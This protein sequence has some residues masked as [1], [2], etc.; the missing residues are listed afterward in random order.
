MYKKGPHF[1]LLTKSDRAI[2]SSI[3]SLFYRLAKIPSMQ[4]NNLPNS[5]YSI[6]IIIIGNWDVT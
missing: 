4:T 3:N 5:V 2:T 1:S 6:L